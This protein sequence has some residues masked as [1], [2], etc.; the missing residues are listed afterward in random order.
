MLQKHHLQ[1]YHN[2]FIINDSYQHHNVFIINYIFNQHH[3]VFIINDSYK[4]NAVQTF[5]FLIN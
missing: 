2:V 1:S 4:K 5:L 3:N